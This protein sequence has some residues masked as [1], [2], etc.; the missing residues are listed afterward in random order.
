[1]WERTAG[2]RKTQVARSAIAPTGSPSRPAR[3][4]STATTLAP[5]RP[6]RALAD[7]GVVAGGLRPRRVRLAI[8]VAGV[9][10]RGGIEGRNC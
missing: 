4:L 2:L 9:F 8:L 6:A 1:M 10:P 3:P 7:P 5:E